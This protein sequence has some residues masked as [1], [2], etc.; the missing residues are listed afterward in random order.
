MGIKFRED[1][2][3]ALLQYCKEEDL[4]ILC[5]Y[6]THDKDGEERMAGEL[7]KDGNFIRYNGYDDQCIRCWQLIAAELQLY[8]G[9]SIVNA[10]RGYGVLYKEIL[11]DVCGKLKVDFKKDE[12]TYE[13][14]NHLLEKMVA[15][16]WEKMT[17]DQQKSLLDEI[18][19][20]PG[21][22][23]TAGL[24]ALQAAIRLGGFASYQ[25]ALVVANTV[26]KAIIGR[27]LTLAANAGLARSL[28][29]FA[30]PIGWVITA[31]LTVPLLS[32]PAYRVTVPSVI[33]VAYMRRALA[34]RNRF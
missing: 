8:G 5:R 33:Q 24:A 23:A 15:D 11:C 17:P 9:D 30:G 25:I 21:L 26:A 1:E 4:R 13:I 28:A 3:L 14:E 20:D 18:G 6:L 31:L 34:E 27:G 16:S 10:F 29:I 12:K 2:D 19:I 22:S 32:G 7:L